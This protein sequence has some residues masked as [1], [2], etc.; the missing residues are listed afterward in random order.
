MCPDTREHT[1]DIGVHLRPFFRVRSI[2]VGHT[3]SRSPLREKGWSSVPNT[4]NETDSVVYGSQVGK[5]LV[6]SS[7]TPL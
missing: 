4:Q 7:L 3:W 1:T 5:Y 6:T 2:D